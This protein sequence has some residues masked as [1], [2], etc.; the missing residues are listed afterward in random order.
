MRGRLVLAALL[1]VL[2]TL[3]VH[4]DPIRI[5]SG[6]LD[7]P[8]PK[9]FSGPI[10]F[11]DVE[12]FDGFH[13][14]VQGDTHNGFGHFCLPCAPGDSLS[15]AGEFQFGFFQAVGGPLPPNP[16]WQ[17]DF[18]GPPSFQF[19]AG[20][21]IVPPVGASAILSAPFKFTGRLRFRNDASE[22][23]DVEL[24][25]RGT[26]TVELRPE[27]G[28]LLWEFARA[29]YEF[30]PVPEPTTLL[31]VSSGLAAVAWRRGHRKPSKP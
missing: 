15:L 1:W 11:L 16:P 19:E 30:A 21:V 13:L 22:I 2:P 7:M 17:P 9:V 18:M 3:S 10:G 27:P 12:G 25:G 29:R 8:D 24:F 14:I 31:L 23:R 5:T 4:A 26:G 28:F 20:D 6:S